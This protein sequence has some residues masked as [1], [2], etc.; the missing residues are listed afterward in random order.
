VKA[1]VE[2]NGLRARF[3]QDR[4]LIVELEASDVVRCY[5]AAFGSVTDSNDHEFWILELERQLLV[6][7]EDTAGFLTALLP[8]WH[9]HWES[10]QRIFKIRCDQP[11]LAWVQ[12]TFFIPTLN[13]QLALQEKD[14]M[15]QPSGTWIV[16]GPFSLQEAQR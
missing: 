16:T 8:A 3:L 11:P 9:Q 15:P 5:H 12:R 14:S 4:H 10:S 2:V 1:T 6:V 13:V 7:P